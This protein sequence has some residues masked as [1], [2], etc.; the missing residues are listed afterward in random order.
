MNVD[1]LP[2]HHT[3]TPSLQ[4]R[5]FLWM[6]RARYATFSAMIHIV[7][8]ILGGSAVLIKNIVEPPDFMAEPGSLI[9]SDTSVAPPQQTPQ[10][11][12]NAFTPT[13]P[14]AS[15]SAPSLTAIASMN[16]S[17]DTF[18]LERHAH[19]ERCR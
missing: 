1:T 11:Q 8:I 16:P 12:Q 9:T 14:S 10:V 5:I 6:G 15:A 18:H 3:E 19:A 17:A 4:A 2:S 7:L 13:A